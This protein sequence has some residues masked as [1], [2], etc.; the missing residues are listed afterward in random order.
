MFLLFLLIISSCQKS[1]EKAILNN[2]FKTE[3]IK[4][5]K[6][7]P[8]GSPVYNAPKAMYQVY[9]EKRN[10][11]TIIAIKLVPHLI[12]F[13]IIDHIKPKDSLGLSSEIEHEGYFLLNEIPIVVFDSDNHSKSIIVKKSLKNPL[14]E[15]YKFEIGKTS[16][17]LYNK[18]KYFKLKKGK[19]KELSNL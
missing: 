18:A 3:L 2:E 13:S 9:F 4:Y 11:D 15:D 1:E 7:N 16:R 10:L 14:P 8:V 5:I 12:P 17:H 6:E 19:L